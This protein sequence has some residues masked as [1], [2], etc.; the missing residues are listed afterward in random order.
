MSTLKMENCPLCNS[1]P[2]LA[3]YMNSSKIEGYTVVCTNYKCKLKSL[4]P[5]K[6]EKKAI[7]KWNERKERKDGKGNH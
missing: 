7:V 2:K 4:G 1:S 3:Y 6:T 5:C